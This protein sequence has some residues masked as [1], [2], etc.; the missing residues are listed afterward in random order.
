MEEILLY[1]EA[2]EELAEISSYYWALLEILSELDTNTMT[3][4]EYDQAVEAEQTIRETLDNLIEV[5]I[6]VDNI[7]FDN[8]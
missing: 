2:K 6:I 8:Q 3:D 4:A 7:R 5:E 1:K